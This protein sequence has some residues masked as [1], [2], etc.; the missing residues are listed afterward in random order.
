MLNTA[1][2]FKKV[3][4]I[5]G[6]SDMRKGIDGLAGLIRLEYQLDPFEQEVIYLF[7]GH[8]AGK[9]KALVWEGDG[10]L[11]LSKRLEASGR[12]VWPRNRSEAIELSH[13]QFEWLMKGL[14]VELG[15]KPST[16]CFS[17]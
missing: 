1:K 2:E 3:V 15:I 17:I 5:T 14:P 13:E 16:R 4:L 8:Q 12:F 6:Y 9:I 10:F 7:C 11:L